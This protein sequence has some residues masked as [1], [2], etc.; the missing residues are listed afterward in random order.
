MLFSTWPLTRK[1]ATT[2]SPFGVVRRSSASTLTPCLRA[3]PSMACAGALL[4]GPVTSVS[5]SWPAAATPGISTASRRGVAKLFAATPADTS[6]ALASSASSRSRNASDSA[7]K[8]LGGSSSVRISTS[9]ASG[10]SH[11]REAEALARLV[12]GLRHRARQRAHAPDVGGALGDRDRAARV[13][14]VEG[15]RSLHHHLVAGQDALRGDQAFRLGFVLPEVTEQDVRVRQLEVVAR[16]LDFVLVIYVEIGHA[17]RP[18]QVVDAFLALQVHRQALQT[19]GDLAQHRLA[20]EAADFLEVGELRDFH[21]VEPHFPAQ[22]P[23]AER[24]RLPVVLDEADVVL[25]RVD[26]QALQRV[27]VQLLDIR[28]RGFQD[29]LVLVIVLQAVRIVAVAPVLRPARG[30]HVRRAPGLGA[31]RAQE[32]GG[33]EGAGADF[34]VVGLQQLASLAVPESVQLQDE[35]LEGRHAPNSSG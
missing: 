7:R 24:G 18:H 10:M 33:V 35:L 23:G 4:E 19:V 1:R 17:R 3:K 31:D 9:S 21:A 5:R 6:W 11:H 2:T 29:D 8:D 22:A 20:G 16:L 14:Q 30:L 34:H 13:E 27:E 12:V 26:A 28:R 15:V 25:E 32:G